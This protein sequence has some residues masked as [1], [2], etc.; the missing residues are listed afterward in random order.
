[1]RIIA[2][3][4]LRDFWQKHPQ[5]REPLLAWHALAARAQWTSPSGVKEAYRNASF[6]PGNRVVFN[7]KGNDYR[8]IVALHHNR[9]IAYIRFVGTHSQY[10]DID[11]SNI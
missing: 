5:A 2:L 3:G 6:L 8:L 11:A 1:M 10:D 9:Q 4:T 7:I